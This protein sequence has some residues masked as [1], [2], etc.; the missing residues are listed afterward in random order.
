MNIYFYTSAIR[1]L[2][3]WC[4]GEHDYWITEQR[5]RVATREAV[6]DWIDGDTWA[7]TIVEVECGPVSN[8]VQISDH[9]GIKT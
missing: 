3:L 2:K 4:S 6:G 7:G 1:R 8:I 5:L 9:V